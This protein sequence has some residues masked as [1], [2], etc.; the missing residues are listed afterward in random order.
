MVLLVFGVF[1]IKFLLA[2]NEVNGDHSFT[3]LSKHVPG[4]VC[5]VLERLSAPTACHLFR[6]YLW[7]PIPEGILRFVCLNEAE[8]TMVPNRC[9]LPSAYGNATSEKLA[10]FMPLLQCRRGFARVRISVPCIVLNQLYCPPVTYSCVI[11][12]PSHSLCRCSFSE[13][14]PSFWASRWFH[15]RSKV[16]C[17]ECDL[18]QAIALGAARLERSPLPE[19]CSWE[20]N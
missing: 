20:L 8:S 5:V 16:S 12:W 1:T 3:A 19:S 9:S 18:A 13:A 4:G 2:L 7:R 14:Q 10:S 6:Y 15:V 11:C 17:D